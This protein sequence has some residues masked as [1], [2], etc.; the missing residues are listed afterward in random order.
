VNGLVWTAGTIKAE[1]V[2]AKADDVAASGSLL[3]LGSDIAV[4]AY[5]NA[6]RAAIRTLCCET[7]FLGNPVDPLFQDRG[8]FAD[9]FTKAYLD[10]ESEW[11][12][13]AETSGCV[14]GYLLGSVRPDF[15]RILIRSGFLTVSK[16]IFRLICGRYANHARSRRFVRW[17]LTAGFWEQPKHPASAAHLHL[18]LQRGY[19]GRGAG[20]RL[21]E[22][23]EKRLRSTGIQR[24]YGSFF[25]HSKRRP[26]SAYA[27]FGF[28]EFARCPT[29]LFQPEIPGR[30][31]VVCVCK[32]LTDAK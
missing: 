7:G 32:E 27:R 2:A 17:L 16:M 13:I 5:Q 15:D 29:T 26:E 1:E 18:N 8:L 11:A 24:C 14:V 4:R 23:Y 22:T 20:R 12:F 9:L 25:S 31:E 28:Q 3:P 21:W 6:D 10:Y 30:V 19:R